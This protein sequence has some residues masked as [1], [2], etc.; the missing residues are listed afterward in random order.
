MPTMYGSRQTL[1]SICSSTKSIASDRHAIIN[2]IVP[3]IITKI[4]SELFSSS[5][6]GLLGFFI[7]GEVIGIDAPQ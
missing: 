4:F 3:I 7:C 6:S 1:L 5:F 2:K